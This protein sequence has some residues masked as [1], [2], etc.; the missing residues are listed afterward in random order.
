MNVHFVDSKKHML[1]PND[2]FIVASHEVKD[3]LAQYEETSKK[4][5]VS[6][7]RLQYTAMVK[8]FQDPKAIRVREG[9]TLF[10]IKPLPQRGGYVENFNADVPK[11]Y[12]DNLISFFYAARKM[13][14][15]FLFAR[16]ATDSMKR[17]LD[18]AVKKGNNPD[19]KVF[20]EPKSKMFVVKTGEPRK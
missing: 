13:G 19:V 16:A 12:I 15:D 7:E 14:F 9:N 8:M 5:G 2:I 10:T 20:F 17:I 6:P 3:G 1:S 11:N 4:F 18:A